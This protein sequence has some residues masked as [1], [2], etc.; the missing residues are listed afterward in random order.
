MMKIV[1]VH[2]EFPRNANFGGI[3]TYQFNLA[4][5]LTRFGHEVTVITASEKYPNEYFHS[6]GF[7]VIELL[8]KDLGKND[9]IE[10]ELKFQKLIF[11]T[12]IKLQESKKVDIVEAPEWK[13]S[14]NY[15]LSSLDRRV[16]VITKLHTPLFVWEKYNNQFSE[17]SYSRCMNNWEKKQILNSDFVFSCSQNLLNVVK[18]KIK[19]LQS[20]KVVPNMFGES[21]ELPKTISNEVKT[22]VYVGSMENRKGIFTLTRFIHALPDN[23]KFVF[24]G[25]DTNRNSNRVSSISLLKQL[26]GDKKN[27]EYKGELSHKE[28]LEY[29]QHFADVQIVPSLYD[30]Q[31]YVILEGFLTGVPVIASN[32]G[33]IPELFGN[34]PDKLKLL[35]NPD[36]EIKLNELFNKLLN[37]TFRSQIQRAQRQQLNL[38]SEKNI[39]KKQVN[40]YKRVI[41]RYKLNEHF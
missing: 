12:L 18:G 11:S 17:D 4:V 21:L 24:I 19:N 35:Y 37:P 5:A 15:F 41:K 27:V 31:P 10:S 30:N 3:S 25:K 26:I 40:E 34:I 13:A 2:E 20:A 7:R 29:L 14:L 22:V 16:P 23:I 8:K 1:L 9:S 39:V 28:V 38:F 32:R 36:D 6:K 33:G